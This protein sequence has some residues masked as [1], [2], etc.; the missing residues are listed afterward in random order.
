MSSVRIAYGVGWKIALVAELFGADSGLGYL[1]L[2]AE[3]MSDTA[4]VFATCFA[5]VII[6]AAGE[7]LIIDPLARRFAPH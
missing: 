1:M 2:R 4:M 3:V 5:I 6:F 7:K